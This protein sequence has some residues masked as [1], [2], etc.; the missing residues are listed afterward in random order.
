MSCVL[1]ASAPVWAWF[2]MIR[3]IMGTTVTFKPDPEIFR[4]TTDYDYEIL[5]T[6]MREQAFLN[7]GLKIKTVDLRE[8]REQSDEMHYAGGIR[9]FVAWM[10]RT[11]DPIHSDVIYMAGSKDDSMALTDKE[12]TESSEEA[13]TMENT[14]AMEETESSAGTTPEESEA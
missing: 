6:R 9:E 14:E 2:Y 11:K 4:D 12:D 1:W 10:N 8:G 7:A 5:H 13:E 3:K